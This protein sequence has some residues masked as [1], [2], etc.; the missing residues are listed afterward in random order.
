M[1]LVLD[2]RFSMEQMKETAAEIAKT[3]KQHSEVFRNVR[4]NLVDWRPGEKPICRVIPLP[5]LMMGN[6]VEQEEACEGTLYADELFEYLRLFQ[7]RSKLILI[8]TSGGVKIEDEERCRKALKP[9]LGRK[10][11]WMSAEKEP[12]MEEFLQKERCHYSIFP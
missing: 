4:L 9:F 3:L 8:V 1:A 11:I 7:A 6:F 5:V 12:V 2:G 10:F